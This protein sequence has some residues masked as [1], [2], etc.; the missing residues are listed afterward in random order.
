MRFSVPS[1]CAC[2][3]RKFCVRLEIRDSA[4]RRPSVATARCDSSPCA[5]LELLRTMPGSLI[6]LGRDLDR[7]ALARAS[8]TP[9]EH[10]LLLRRKSL[11]RVDEVRNQV[12]AALVLVHD[13]RPGGLHL[14]VLR[15]QSCCSRSRTTRS[16]RPRADQEQFQARI[17]RSPCRALVVPEELTRSVTRWSG[18][19]YSLSPGLT[20]NASSNAGMLRDDAVGSGTRSGLCGSVSRRLRS[21]SSRYLRAR[22]A[23]SRGRSAGRR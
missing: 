1:S 3:S 23:P 20:P 2:R 22:P 7:V 14:L 8:V 5:C 17:D 12:G 15:L 11:D 19:R 16:C 21:S 18:G 13:F 6:E 10:V 4:R 9:I